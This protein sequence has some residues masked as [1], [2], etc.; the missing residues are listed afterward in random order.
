MGVDQILL[1]GDERLHKVST[2]VTKQE[3]E[4]LKPII[5]KLHETVIEFR[6]LH[7]R[8]RAIA[9]P[10]L[11]VT[12]RI[13]CFNVDTPVTMINPVI[14]D[15]SEEKIELWDDCMSFPN[16]LVRVERYKSCKITFYDMEWNRQTWDL[17]D[18]LS[19]LFQHE[20][21]H[22]D[23]VLATER[24]IDKRSFKILH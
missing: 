24:A 13:I 18:D 16:L 20:Y 1:L 3:L 6:K 5:S 8:G 23:G 15:K 12:K 10:Q 17:I 22:L 19:E 7:S 2:E 9:A 14:H 11:G 4:G 21:D